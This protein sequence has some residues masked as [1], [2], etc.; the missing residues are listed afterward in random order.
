MTDLFINLYWKD[1]LLGCFY[2]MESLPFTHPCVFHD[3]TMHQTLRL[4]KARMGRVGIADSQASPCAWTEALHSG[5]TG[6]TLLSEDRSRL[7]K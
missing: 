1:Q 7:F 2:L 6:L 5:L 3:T 4:T